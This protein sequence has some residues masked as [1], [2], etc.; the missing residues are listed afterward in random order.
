MWRTTTTY[1]NIK[2]DSQSESRQQAVETDYSHLLQA[3]LVHQALPSMTTDNMLSACCYI[4]IQCMCCFAARWYSLSLL[5]CQQHLCL[6]WYPDRKQVSYE[7]YW[8]STFSHTGWGWAF[9]ANGLVTLTFSPDRPLSP[10]TPG[11]VR[12]GR[13]CISHNEGL[14][15]LHSATLI[16]FIIYNS[17]IFQ[18]RPRLY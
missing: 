13:P 9:S 17:F 6:L 8:K 4:N 3:L 12:P 7:F 2:H 15:Q 10:A 5:W 16:C 1:S 11:S 14:C 18:F